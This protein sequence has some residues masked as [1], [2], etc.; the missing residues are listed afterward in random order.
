MNSEET[1]DL[2]LEKTKA[3]IEKLREEIRGLRSERAAWRQAVKSVTTLVIVI[4][5]VGGL[6]L[7]VW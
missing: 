4:V 2:D 1:K 5:A 6:W 7:S 3:E